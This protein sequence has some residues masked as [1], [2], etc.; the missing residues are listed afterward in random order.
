MSISIFHTSGPGGAIKHY[1][2]KV[3]QSAQ[4]TAIIFD[5]KMKPGRAVTDDLVT[6]FALLWRHCQIRTD[7]SGL[8][9]M[10]STSPGV[11]PKA[12][13]RT[14]KRYSTTREQGDMCRYLPT[15]GAT[16]L[17]PLPWKP[18]TPEMV[19]G[20]TRAFGLTGQDLS[21]LLGVQSRQANSFIARQG[22]SQFL[23]REQWEL[24]L[25]KAKILDFPAFRVR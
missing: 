3:E 10:Q 6:A 19:L 4:V 12:A 8:V 20:F 11:I 18:P 22:R 13:F 25:A 14:D 7:G 21:I 23:K 9:K 2:F 1:P 17:E 24:L 16:Q 15:W 5:E